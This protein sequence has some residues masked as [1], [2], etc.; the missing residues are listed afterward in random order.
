[1]TV[2]KSILCFQL[3]MLL[4]P[5][6]QRIYSILLILIFLIAQTPAQQLLKLPLLI[7][8]FNEHKQGRASFDLGDFFKMHYVD[9]EKK[10]KDYEKDMRLPFKKNDM[11]FFAGV[12]LCIQSE[13]LE[14]E[15]VSVVSNK[16]YPTIDP[17][18]CNWIHGSIWQPPKEILG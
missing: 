5:K 4:L 6:L 10:D 18:L 15:P 3:Y 7:E 11:H 16:I 13:Y 12:F 17:A 14:I 9:A 1:M 2:I 8:H